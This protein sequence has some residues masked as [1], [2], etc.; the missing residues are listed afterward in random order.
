MDKVRFDSQERLDIPDALALQQLGYDYDAAELGGLLGLINA[1]DELQGGSLFAGG[2]ITVPTID[3]TD[4]ASI[5]VGPFTL[6][7]IERTATGKIT[8]QVVLCPGGYVTALAGASPATP[9]LWFRREES[10]GTAAT[11]RKWATTK[12]AAYSPNTRLMES[13]D[14]DRAA[15]SRPATDTTWG[16][17]PWA[18]VTGWT[19]PTPTIALLSAWD[20]FDSGADPGEKTWD[21]GPVLLTNDESYQSLRGLLFYMRLALARQRDSDDGTAWTSA[22]PRGLKQLDADLTAAEADVAT[23]QDRMI[24]AACTCDVAAP[25]VTINGSYANLGISTSITYVGVGIYHVSPVTPIALVSGKFPHA[26]AEPAGGGDDYRLRIQVTPH[27][28]GLAV[29]YFVLSV[30]RVDTGVAADPTSFHFTAF[31]V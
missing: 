2:C 28:N 23:V 30:S 31:A 25:D 20:S 1:D 13:A 11:R 7:Q 29:D 8:S 18:K 19:G 6:M 27:D 22:P 17:F 14:I 16:W 9:W 12:E 24:V 21:A 15:T 26:R 3:T 5:V 10:E 4:P